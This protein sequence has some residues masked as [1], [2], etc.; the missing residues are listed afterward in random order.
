MRNHIAVTNGSAAQV[1]ETSNNRP[2]LTFNFGDNW[3]EARNALLHDA[4]GR[5]YLA[6]L[7]LWLDH[8]EY[9]ETPMTNAQALRW[10]AEANKYNNDGSTGSIGDLC[11]AAA[12]EIADLRKIIA[13]RNC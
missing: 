1:E 9:D 6:D 3:P 2:L 13:L 10:Y 8:G 7:G 12:A 11:L 5:F 4:Q